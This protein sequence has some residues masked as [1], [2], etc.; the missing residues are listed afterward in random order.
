M[1]AWLGYEPDFV[2]FDFI[3]GGCRVSAESRR[4]GKGV[5]AA[6]EYSCNIANLVITT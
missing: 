5:A 6:G 3:A 2:F 4:G 1:L